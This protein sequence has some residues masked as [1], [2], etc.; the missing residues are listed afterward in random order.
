MTLACF[1]ISGCIRTP[2]IRNHPRHLR[3]QRRQLGLTADFERDYAT[4]FAALLSAAECSAHRNTA[5]ACERRDVLLAVELERHRPAHDCVLRVVRPE[6]R[7][8][9]RGIC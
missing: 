7:T 5:D 2:Q 1:D 4:V 8:G 6:L 9:V 3:L